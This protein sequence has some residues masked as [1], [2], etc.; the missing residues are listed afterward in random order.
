MRATL[1]LGGLAALLANGP[2]LAD[3]LLDGWARRGAVYH[4]IDMDQGTTQACHALCTADDN[5]QSWVWT[6]PG[7]NGPDARCELLSATPTPFRSPGRTT[8]LSGQLSRSLDQAMD[9][10]PSEREIRAMR[11][12]E[13]GPDVFP[14]S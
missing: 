12:L 3:D 4:R 8:G 2:T 14:D 1:C 9:R 11:A 5:C 13:P 7:L 10:A 6:R